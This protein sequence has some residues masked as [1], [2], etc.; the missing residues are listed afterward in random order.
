MKLSLY[1]EIR[2]GYTPKGDIKKCLEEISG[3]EVEEAP[4]NLAPKREVFYERR[5][6]YQ[7]GRVS[8]IPE[9]GPWVLSP[10]NAALYI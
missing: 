10:F 6:W 9:K 2:A 3:K 7:V 5:R 8:P 4:P 1:M